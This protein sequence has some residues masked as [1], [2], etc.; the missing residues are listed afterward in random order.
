IETPVFMPIGTQGTVKSL[1]PDEIAATGNR[2]ILGNT[3]HLYLRP[4]LEILQQAGGLHKFANWPYV[5]LTDSGGYQV[6]SLSGLRKI[7]PDG[8]RFQSHID[9]SSHEFTPE[10]VIEKQRVIGADIMMVLDECPPYPSTEIYCA[11]SNKLTIAW[12]QRCKAAWEKQE[13]LYGYEQALFGIVQGG[14]Y[15]HLRELSARQLIDVDFPGYAI[16][17]LAVGEPVSLLYEMAGIVNKILPAE[18]PR[19]LM[20]VGKPD[21]LVE[22][23]RLGVDMFDC[24]IPTRNGRKGQAFTWQGTVNLR[25]TK[26]KNYFEPIEYDCPCYTC[27][28]FTCAYLR[29]LFQAGELLGM[30]LV[31][32]HNIHF[33]YTFMRQMR[34]A[35]LDDRFEEWRGRFYRNYRAT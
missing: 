3:Y 24:V 11:E 23:V 25:N 27:T 33:F 26:F 15:P 22:S 1:T 20:G 35:I 13:P 14:I 8:V 2:L 6:F 19:Y 10:N 31:S 17:G 5:I 9:G 32:L 21:N 30:R 28:N 4:G 12:A 29:H 34:D 16:G 18:K 7:H